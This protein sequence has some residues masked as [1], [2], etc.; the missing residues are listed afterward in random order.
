MK[1]SRNLIVMLFAF[2]AILMTSCN[3]FKSTNQVEKQPAIETLIESDMAYVTENYGN[4]FVWYE[5]NVIYNNFLDEENDGSYQSVKS[6]YQYQNIDQNETSIDVKVI[7]I[8]HENGEVTIETEDTWYAECFDLRHSDINI[9]FE[10]AYNL[11]M[12]VN[13]PKP[14][15]KC[16]VLRDQV[17]PVAANPQYIYGTGLLFVDAVNGMV[18]EFNPVFPHAIKETEN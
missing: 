11:I 7:T 18:S 13:F 2:I 12:S 5:T 17:G 9:T 6:V 14:H 4:T 3:W 15:T 8:Y 1:K 10:E 16:C